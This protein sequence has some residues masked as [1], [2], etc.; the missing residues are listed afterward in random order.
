VL[1]RNLDPSLVTSRLARER[2]VTFPL[3]M[4]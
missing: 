3:I 4:S 1:C 2:A